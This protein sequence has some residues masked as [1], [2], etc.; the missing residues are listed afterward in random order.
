MK[1]RR[2]FSIIICMLV[3]LSAGA[4][5]IQTP[6]AQTVMEAA[7]KKAGKE[8]KK[9]LVIFHAS[10]CG[11]CHKMDT[12]LNDV[13]CKSFFDKNYVIE[14]LTVYENKSKENLENP[15]AEALLESFN[16]K[17]QGLPYWVILDKSGKLLFDS[18]IRRVGTDGTVKGLNIGC[19]ASDEEVKAFI[20]ILEQTSSLTTDELK[21]IAERF[22]KNKS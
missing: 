21:I 15:G 20:K 3:T 18:Q 4:Q 14:H 16:G 5:N 1:M 11:W 22:A 9:V 7:Y 2:F 12:S 10:W 8:N 17:D 13:S 6:A 19:P